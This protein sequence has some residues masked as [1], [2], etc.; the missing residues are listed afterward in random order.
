MR[1]ECL[2]LGRTRA[3]GKSQGE[4]RESFVRRWGGAGVGGEREREREREL[5]AR[6]RSLKAEQIKNAV[7][8]QCVRSVARIMER[9]GA[10]GR[11]GR[12]NLRRTCR[13]PERPSEIPSPLS[14]KA[15]Q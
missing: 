10:V 7:P 1:R 4:S 6:L 11:S 2:I 12:A 15:A 13:A 5:E 9:L 3:K 8:D 14:Q